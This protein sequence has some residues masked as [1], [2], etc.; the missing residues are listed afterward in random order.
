MRYCSQCGAPVV[1]RVPEG[2]NLPRHV[3]DACSTIHYDNPRIVAGCIVTHD[4]KILICR[5]AIEPRKGFWTLPAGFMEHGETVAQAAAREAMEE[6]CADVELDA[7]YAIV[8]VIH[9]GQVHMMYRGILKGGRHKP[10]PESTETALVSIADIPWDELAFPSVRFTL[11][12][13]R[14][15][16][17]TGRFGLHSQV[18]DRRA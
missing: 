1:L 4:E 11:E 3:C 17:E 10:G 8:D 13:Y 7:L 6:A 5:R 15:D 9:V 12:R 14:E 18:F 16:L 2:D